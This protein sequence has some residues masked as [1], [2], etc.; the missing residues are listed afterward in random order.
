MSEDIIFSAIIPCSES[1]FKSQ[2]LQDLIDSIR[3]QDFPQDQIEILTITEGDSEQAKAIGIRRAKGEICAMFCADNYVYKKETFERVNFYFHTD[4][5]LTGVFSKYYLVKKNDNSLNRYFSL[6]GGN[7][8][9]CFYLDKNDRKPHYLK[10]DVP[11]EFE[12]VNFLN[13]KVPSLGCNGFFYRRDHIIKSNLDNYYPMDNASELISRGMSLF[14]RCMNMDIWHRT[15]DNLIRFLIKRYKYARDLYSDRTNRRWRMLDTRED[16][17]RLLWF[18]VATVTVLPCIATSIRG[19][20]KVRDWAWAWHWPVC[21]GFL[22]TYG[23][24]VCRNILKYQSLSQ[25]FSVQKV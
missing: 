4:K 9:I 12:A 13:W 14:Y 1:D 15:S 24:L 6:I 20:L 2:K 7:D 25:A 3:S 17:L 18:V 16:Y 11:I 23:A 19:F 22:I 21:F 8:P 10:T 5:D